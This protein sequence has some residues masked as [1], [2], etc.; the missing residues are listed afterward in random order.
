MHPA[1]LAPLLFVWLFYAP[2]I[3]YLQFFLPWDSLSSVQTIA[4]VFGAIFVFS[5]A[6]SMSCFWL[7]ELIRR[8]ESGESLN[9]LATLPAAVGNVFRAF[10]VTLLWALIWFVLTLLASLFRR[11]GEKDDESFSAKNAAKTLSGYA[12]ASLSGAFFDALKKGVRMI[13]FL[14]YPA[15]AWESARAPIK[16]GLGV[17]R[18]HATEF[19]S[20]FILTEL[21]AAIV[22]LPPALLF[23]V[24]DEAEIVLSDGVWYVVIVYCAF[25]WSI[26]ILLEQLFAAE[27]YLWDMKW[28]KACAEAQDR[29]A[30][31][32]KLR[33]VPR[34]SILDDVKEFG[35]AIKLQG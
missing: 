6:L 22:F 12:S 5:V 17:A 29:G 24:T 3:L 9:I 30:V 16:R 13:A 7:L 15:V 25:A 28:R 31:A 27:L 14:I 34:P 10:H 4:V 32:P 20:G 33:D 23:Y 19:A 21:A 18:T 2:A 35:G 8:I 1:L 26:S 11:R